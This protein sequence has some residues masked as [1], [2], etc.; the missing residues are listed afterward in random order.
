V[1][2]QPTE[3]GHAQRSIRRYATGNALGEALR[4]V[5]WK[6]TASII[7]WLRHACISPLNR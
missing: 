4:S 3:L 2:F 6:P 1:G 5:G 7:L